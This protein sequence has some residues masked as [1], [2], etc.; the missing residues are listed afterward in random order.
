M[1]DNMDIPTI[2]KAVKLINKEA[3]VEVS[4]RVNLENVTEIAATGVDYISIGALTHSA[5]AVDIS[6]E[7]R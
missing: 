3:L 6:M 2:K 1:L 7:I 4:G 5:R